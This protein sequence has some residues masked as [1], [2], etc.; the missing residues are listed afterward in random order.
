MNFFRIS[1]QIPVKSDVCR[2]FNRI[3]KNKLENCRKF[4]NLW[5]LF[6][7]IHY[8]SFVSLD[9]GRAPEALR[10]AGARAAPA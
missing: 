5:K 1:R 7:I 9:A 6:I 4:W 3:Y 8:N 10:N 2:F